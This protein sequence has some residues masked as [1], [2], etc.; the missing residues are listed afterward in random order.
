MENKLLLMRFLFVNF[1]FFG[2]CSTALLF[3]D[4][5]PNSTPPPASNPNPIRN[6]GLNSTYRIP[7]EEQ[8]SA[9]EYCAFLKTDA[10]NESYYVTR[11]SI[12][13]DP[14]FM[15]AS[16]NKVHGDDCILRTG[17]NGN[18]NFSV[19]PGREN[20]T[21][22]GLN[23]KDAYDLFREWNKHPTMA[24]V[25]KYVNY[26][27]SEN[28]TKD[29]SYAEKA[30]AIEIIYLRRGCEEDEFLQLNRL[31]SDL[32]DPSTS[33]LF[34]AQGRAD[35][36]LTSTKI[37]Q[38]LLYFDQSATAE[39]DEASSSFNDLTSVQLPIYAHLFCYSDGFYRPDV[40]TKTIIPAN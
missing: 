20:Y 28:V 19:L 23:S 6:V 16:R 12:Y 7:I 24:E 27:I 11:W 29:A 2:L 14:A 34:N 18:W 26:K 9:L 21:I 25:Q 39:G 38:G 36:Y 4:D 31:V 33:F 32:L 3:A 30:Y 40:L 17:S 1:L 15:T 8:P 35:I 13:Y 10:C 22:T 37:G 5:P